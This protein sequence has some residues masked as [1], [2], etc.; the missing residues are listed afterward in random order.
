MRIGQPIDWSKAAALAGSAE[1]TDGDGSSTG[2]STRSRT[3]AASRPRAQSPAETAVLGHGQPVDWGKVAHPVEDV[4]VAETRPAG[5][6]ANPG[7]E[8]AA[9]GSACACGGPERAAAAHSA[10]SGEA[11]DW[12]RAAHRNVALVE[13]PSVED[14]ATVRLSVGPSKKAAPLL[15]IMGA[16]F[17]PSRSSNPPVIGNPPRAWESA[18]WQV[19]WPDIL[20]V[21]PSGP[22]CFRN[23]FPEDPGASGLDELAADVTFL[24]NYLTTSFS[25]SDTASASAWVAANPGAGE[26][27][28]TRLLLALSDDGVTWYKTGLVVANH[29]GVP[30]VAVEGDRLYVFFNATLDGAT[31]VDGLPA[32][33][34]TGDP[35]C[36]AYTTDLR[37]WTYRIIGNHSNT[38]G[39]SYNSSGAGEGDIM[40]LNAHDP[41]VVRSTLSSEAGGGEGWWLFYTLHWDRDGTRTSGTFFAEAPTLD[42]ANWL[43]HA[44]KI[45]PRRETQ[46]FGSAEDPS[47]IRVETATGYYLQ[48]AAGWTAVDPSGDT[49]NNWIVAL[50][51]SMTQDDLD[52]APW[53]LDS[54]SCWSSGYEIRL[55][56][57]M[58]QS[59]GE[60][61][62][63][64][65]PPA[66]S[67]AHHERNADSLVRARRGSGSV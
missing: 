36:C 23:A 24:A 49:Y 30:A 62:G 1:E 45:F 31:L 22:E 7:G 38:N 43:Q 3:T 40:A 63:V 54:S 20:P 28:A 33:A 61:F 52:A 18:D 60:G 57:P 47:V 11:L 25:P 12:S 39:I 37:S 65:P 32:T 56:N 67:S 50:P 55:G 8:K 13:H 19:R 26:P 16:G 9:R 42:A 34:D 35:L 29:A 48:Y 6:Q 27:A 5:R 66:R 4:G 51:S 41:S 59:A 21:N 15:P 17:A 53:T 14:G 64:S 44:G 10:G 2:M 58:A 46:G